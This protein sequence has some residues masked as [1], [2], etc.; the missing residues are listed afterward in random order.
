V[1][2]ANATVTA[3]RRTKLKGCGAGVDVIAKNKCESQVL[4]DPARE[5]P[6]W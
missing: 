1:A 3:A 4:S 6:E 2:S 5:H